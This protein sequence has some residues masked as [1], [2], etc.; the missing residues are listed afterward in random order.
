MSRSRCGSIHVFMKSYDF[1]FTH[2]E[3]MGKVT[4]ELSTSRL[5]TPGVMTKSDDFVSV[6]DKLSWLNVLNVLGVYQ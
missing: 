1:A 5:N 6:S 3:H 4:S 2:C